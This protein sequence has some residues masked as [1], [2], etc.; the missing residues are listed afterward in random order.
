M[1]TYMG[2]QKAN[3]INCSAKDDMVFARAGDDTING[4]GGNDHIWAGAGNDTL[5]GG[6][7]DDTL[8]GGAGADLFA[9]YGFAGA[10]FGND[11]IVDFSSI[12]GDKISFELWGISYSNLSFS[13]T[14]D[15]AT[16]ISVDTTNDAIPDFQITLDN[17]TTVTASDFIF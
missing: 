4:N 16:I 2:N 9:Y 11:H 14:T 12:D 7:G 1:S 3:T 8:V 6:A 5:S 17:V 13:N 15:G 10:S